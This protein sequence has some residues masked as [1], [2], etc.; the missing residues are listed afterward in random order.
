MIGILIC[1]DFSNES[2]RE[3]RRLNENNLLKIYLYRWVFIIVC[4]KKVAFEIYYNI[5]LKVF[6]FQ[7]LF[8]IDLFDNF[9]NNYVNLVVKIPFYCYWIDKK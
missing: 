2:C 4:R 7:S 9:R 1:L 5:L 6:K 8:V 3:I